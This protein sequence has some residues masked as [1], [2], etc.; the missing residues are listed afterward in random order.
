MAV[1]AQNHIELWNQQLATPCPGPR[2]TTSVGVIPQGR[3]KLI[4]PSG[5][6]LFTAQG[7]NNIGR[8]NPKTGNI[9]VQKTPTERANP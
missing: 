9:K 8:I 7:A 1:R 2:K 6:V 5:M 3:L 4:A